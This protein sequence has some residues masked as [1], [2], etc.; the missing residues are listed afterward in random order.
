[1]KRRTGNVV[2]FGHGETL[3]Y[4]TTLQQ[5]RQMVG[6]SDATVCTT[7]PRGGLQ[8]TQPRQTESARMRLYIRQLHGD[9][10]PAWRAMATG[11]PVRLED[12]LDDARFG[13]AAGRFRDRLLRPFGLEHYTAVP[14]E[15]PVLQGYPGVL[16]LFATREAGPVKE[17]DLRRLGRVA[18]EF[19]EAFDR[20]RERLRFKQNRY[21]LAHHLPHRQFVL[22]RGGEFVFRQPGAVEGLDDVLLHNLL[23]LCRQRMNLIIER[24]TD[25]LDTAGEDDGDDANGSALRPAAAG[26]NSDR[27]LV[28]D[29]LGDCWAFR[30]SV[31][32]RYPA[33]TG[34]DDEPV[35]FVCHQPQCES[36]S[37]LRPS[38]FAADEEVGRLIPS[39]QFMQENFRKKTSLHQI[40]RTVHLSPFHFHRRFTELLGITP[41]HYMFDCQVAE[42]KRKL[43]QGEMDLKEVAEHCGFAHQ[44]HFTSRFKQAVGLT[45][46]RWRRLARDSGGEEF[47]EPAGN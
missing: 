38:D 14:L 41:K 18:E 22:T 28:P 34:D 39:L 1:M 30:L 27:L 3:A 8:V 6:C 11:Q 47:A 42:A 12:V 10:V 16:Q 20:N 31:Y 15:G 23:D 21:P 25:D 7:L 40:A 26:S 33:L 5:L 4:N 19:D 13:R 36:W 45:P 35:A 24:G 43:A 32:P 9:D 37:A 44:S 29:R 17:S 2:E 46:T